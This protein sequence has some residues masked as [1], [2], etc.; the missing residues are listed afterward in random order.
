MDRSSYQDHLRGIPYGL[1]NA[2][3]RLCDNPGPPV[4]FLPRNP[5]VAKAASISL[6]MTS[7]FCGCDSFARGKSSDNTPNAHMAIA[8]LSSS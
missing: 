8:F 2:E 7:S 5:E 4:T 3:P 1:P 6:T